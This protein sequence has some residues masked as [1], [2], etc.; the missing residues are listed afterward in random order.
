LSPVRVFAA[1]SVSTEPDPTAIGPE[2]WVVAMVFL[3]F[4]QSTQLG[5]AA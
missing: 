4:Y 2:K 3:L 1:V 5:L